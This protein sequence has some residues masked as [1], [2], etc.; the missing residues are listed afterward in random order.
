M[1]DVT[2]YRA[3]GG[4]TGETGRGGR[5]EVKRSFG[6]ITYWRTEETIGN[7]LTSSILVSQRFLLTTIENRN[8]SVCRPTRKL[9]IFSEDVQ[10]FTD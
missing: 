9:V 7:Y 1:Q 2:K 4:G 5:R 6:Y 10:I 8:I 3:K